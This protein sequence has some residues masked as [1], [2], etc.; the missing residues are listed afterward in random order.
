[1]VVSHFAPD[2]A[3]A[4]RSEV[5]ELVNAAV[6]GERKD[7]LLR[8][9]IVEFELAHLDVEPGAAEQVVEPRHH[10][11]K[12]ERG[13]IVRRRQHIEREILFERAAGVEV[14]T[15][16]IEAG[17]RDALD[18]CTSHH[19]TSRTI[20]RVGINRHLA[21]AHA[22]PDRRDAERDRPVPGVLPDRGIAV[23]HELVA[24]VFELLSKV[25]QHRPG[26]MA[27]RAAQSI[28]SGEGGQ[29]V[30]GL[31]ATEDD[32]CENQSE[33]REGRRKLQDIAK[34]KTTK[35]VHGRTPRQD[36]IGS[37]VKCDSPGGERVL[38]WQTKRAE[39]GV[40]PHGQS[41]CVELLSG[42]TTKPVVNPN[43]AEGQ[44][45]RGF[46]HKF[47][48]PLHSTRHRKIKTSDL[49]M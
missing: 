8:K 37:V 46:R 12:V 16:K 31:A 38:T 17:T 19:G 26:L 35:N 2:V 41:C 32:A 1:M 24:V 27:G 40:F 39:L 21:G 9:Q 10:G 13:C 43:A 48:L 44:T 4:L 29:G 49:N 3:V 47:S 36:Q 33:S 30:R 6:T 7:A 5:I 14:E 20:R 28:F 25:V 18:C 23:V 11:F 22:V 15:A 45:S 34:T 42:P